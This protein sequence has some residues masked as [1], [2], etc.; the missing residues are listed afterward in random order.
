VEFSHNA[1]AT[2]FL[3]AAQLELG[4]VTGFKPAL[5]AETGA[6]CDRLGRLFYA[7][8]PV[9]L[10]WTLWAEGPPPQPVSLAYRI[11]DYRDRLV[12][13]GRERFAAAKQGAHAQP[14]T[15]Q[16]PAG[17]YRL[18]YAQDG[19]APARQLSLCVVPRP[20]PAQQDCAI[21]TYLTLTPQPLQLADRLGLRWMCSLSPAEHIAGW[22]YVQPDSRDEF[23]FHDDD[24]GWARE[25]HVRILANINTSG[26]RMPQWALMDAAPDG[27][28][29]VLHRGTKRYFR[30]RD[31]EHFVLN[32]VQHYKH[33]IRHWLVIDEPYQQYSAED[34]SRLLEATYRA[35]KRAD[36]GC[37]VFAHGGYYDTWMPQV[38]EAVGPQ[39][40]DGVYDY[41]RYREHAEL[42]ADICRRH[43]K[44]LWSVEYGGVP[45]IYSPP[46]EASLAEPQS[47]FPVMD[48]MNRYLHSAI[49]SLCWAP[50][51]KYMRYDA[52]FPGHLPPTNYMT[53][54]E[55]DGGV[56]PLAAAL[57]NL[58]RL[59]SGAVGDGEVTANPSL[60][61]F[62]FRA[63]GEYIVALWS[64]D[65]ELLRVELPASLLDAGITDAMGA[66]V[67]AAPALLVDMLPI[68]LRVKNAWR[69]QLV[70]AVEELSV[71]R[72]LP[73]QLR[74][75]RGARG[76]PLSLSAVIGNETGAPVSLTC[77]LSRASRYAL[78]DPWAAPA[79]IDGLGP[80]AVYVLRFDLNYYP[81]DVVEDKPIAVSAFG[82]GIGFSRTKVLYYVPIPK[83]Q[84]IVC[85]GDLTEWPL[86][87]PA[88]RARPLTIVG[89]RPNQPG[90]EQQARLQTWLAWSDSA[91]H[92]ALHLTD[93]HLRL[94]TDPR[95][96]RPEQSGQVARVYLSD[97]MSPRDIVTALIVPVRDGPVRATARTRNG[98]QVLQAGARWAGQSWTAEVVLPFSLVPD[99]E[100]RPGADLLFDVVVSDWNEKRLLGDMI[101]AGREAA[102]ED[103]RGFGQI[104]L[105]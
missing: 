50:A 20:L 30:L 17:A 97:S 69:E 42:L 93:A 53:L 100:P 45:T 105:Q 31:W 77:D 52:R 3:D 99:F 55:Y 66:T 21:G 62:L 63:E 35:A 2:V 16:L 58:N 25:H 95:G 8:E 28:P 14:L 92:L 38:I 85:D 19:A 4:D 34:Y 43:G 1:P 9:A 27:E 80:D 79:I 54:F 86:D 102:P 81:G 57:A 68:Y 6:S 47:S 51:A 40:F 91:V 90:D 49:R 87:D 88:A 23:V 60:R 65:G 59:A 46:E 82:P 64:A 32:L 94:S 101:W 75:V 84:P 73:L 98:E 29:C 70:A 56:K 26:Y 78:R 5:A 74:V 103:P 11:Y 104:V 10:D 33:T 22:A 7:D 67:S 12:R 15:A 18:V 71:Q 76:S 41:M 96:P 89:F 72:A 24:V 37:V 44:L 36:P 48:N 39:V 61:C 83:A 13:E